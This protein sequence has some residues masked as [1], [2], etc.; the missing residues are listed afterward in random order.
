MKI[1]CHQY[2]P[3][4]LG[5]HRYSTNKLKLH[6]KWDMTLPGNIREAVK[7]LICLFTVCCC[8]LSPRDQTHNSTKNNC[9]LPEVKHKPDQDPVLI[10]SSIY[11][12]RFYYRICMWFQ[13]F[14]G[15][16]SIMQFIV[17]LQEYTGFSWEFQHWQKFEIYIW[18]SSYYSNNNLLS[19][20]SFSSS[21]QITP[22]RLVRLCESWND[23]MTSSCCE[24]TVVHFTDN[25][26]GFS[27]VI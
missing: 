17:F 6:F 16:K 21:I 27:T 11:L 19:Q 4:V 9:N 23:Q 26:Y 20:H 7:L 15:N 2:N 10:F 1:S 24:R 18:C 14:R 13:D 3:R 8:S 25:Q 5:D 12:Y 22:T